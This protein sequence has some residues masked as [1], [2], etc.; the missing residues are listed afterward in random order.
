MSPKLVVN[1][2]FKG[3][4]GAQIHLDHNLLNYRWIRTWISRS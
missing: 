1:E 4:L 3:S 2:Q